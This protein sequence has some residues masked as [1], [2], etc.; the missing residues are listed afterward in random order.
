M[1]AFK[2]KAIRNNLYQFSLYIPPMDF[3]IHQY[4]LNTD[5]AI[6]FAAGTVQQAAA[7]LPDLKT[8]LGKKPLKYVFVSH[9]ESDEAGGLRVLQKE[10]PDL[11]VI[12]G[13][14]TARELP[15]Y[16]Y[17]GKMITR[18]SGESLT[19]GDLSLSFIDYPSEVH[20]QDG[21][22]AC[23]KNSGILYS[24]DLF[25]RFGNGMGQVIRKDWHSEV[26]HIDTQRVPNEEARKKLQQHLESLHPA[27]LAVGHGYCI[28]CMG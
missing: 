4:L 3:T 6:L 20:L 28:D 16:G 13:A 10:Y 7:I 19:D 11:T 25:L 23:E 18:R 8:I 27:F 5:P 21:L 9:M 2:M 12:A 22:L 24:A 14:I 26:E 17:T 15:G 1:E